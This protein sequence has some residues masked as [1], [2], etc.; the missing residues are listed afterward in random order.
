M[1]LKKLHEM[2]PGKMIRL[3][4]DDIFKQLRLSYLE[5]DGRYERKLYLEHIALAK[6]VLKLKREVKGDILLARGIQPNAMFGEKLLQERVR[7]FRARQR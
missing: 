1:K 3:V 6:Q 2:R 4:D 7:A 5:S